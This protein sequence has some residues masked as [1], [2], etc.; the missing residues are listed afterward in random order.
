MPHKEWTIAL[1]DGSHTVVLE[2]SA[3]G[4]TRSVTVDD[5]CQL[6]ETNHSLFQTGLMNSL[7]LRFWAVAIGASQEVQLI[8]G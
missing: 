7:S 1:E 8:A 5:V 3:L 2:M 4:G 6:Q